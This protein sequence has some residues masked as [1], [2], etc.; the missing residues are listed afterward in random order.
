M[1]QC[2]GF[3]FGKKRKLEVE[4]YLVPIWNQRQDE[5]ALRHFRRSHRAP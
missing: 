3:R 2:N 1:N 5:A 4:L